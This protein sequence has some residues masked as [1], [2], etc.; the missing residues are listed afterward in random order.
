MA[1]FTSNAALLILTS[2]A[3]IDHSAQSVS[4]M[5]QMSQFFV[6][7]A[8]LSPRAFPSEQELESVRCAFRARCSAA[9]WGCTAVG[10]TE[11]F[12]A[13][14]YQYSPIY[15]GGPGRSFEQVRPQRAL[16]SRQAS[17]TR[18]QSYVFDE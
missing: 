2:W 18:L 13:L 10:F 6:N 17:L 9:C 3:G 5:S 15:T 4:V 14:I 8:R 11:T 16:S 1:T 12:Q 7:Q